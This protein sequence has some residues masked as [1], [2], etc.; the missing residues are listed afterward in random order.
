M[1]ATLKHIDIALYVYKGENAKLRNDEDI[2]L[3]IR[4]TEADYKCHLLRVNKL[5]F[6]SIFGFATSFLKSKTLLNEWINDQFKE[7]N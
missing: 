7:L 6:N 3:G 4:S 1:K 5:P 2:S